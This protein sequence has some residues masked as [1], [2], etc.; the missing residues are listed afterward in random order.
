MGF[1]GIQREIHRDFDMIYGWNRN[2]CVMMQIG[3]E[4][5]DFTGNHRFFPSDFGM[6]WT[7]QSDLTQFNHHS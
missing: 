2:E 6:D 1:L 4:W 7:F 5:D 3:M